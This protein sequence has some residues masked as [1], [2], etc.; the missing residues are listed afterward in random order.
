MSISVRSSISS[1][2]LKTYISITY[3]KYRLF[4]YVQSPKKILQNI[5]I[6]DR[7]R[8]WQCLGQC[9]L[10]LEICMAI[11]LIFFCLYIFTDIVINICVDTDGIMLRCI[12]YRLT[13]WIFH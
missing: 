5:S 10:K 3:Y 4:E 11:N 2:G 8:K 7:R 6:V 13:C 9:F 1:T 12:L